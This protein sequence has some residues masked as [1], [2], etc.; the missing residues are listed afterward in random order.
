M[1]PRDLF[2][3]LLCSVLTLA[4][5]VPLAAAQEEPS[6]SAEDESSEDSGF[7]IRDN[8]FL[9]EE[10]YNQE[11]G[12][13]QHI[14]N[15]I[16]TWDR[17]RG[18]RSRTFDFVFTQEWPVGSQTHQ[19]SYTLPFQ[20]VSER[21]DGDFAAGGMCDMMLNY[22][23]QVFDGQNEPFAF[24]PRFSLILPTGDSEKGLG[25]DRVGYQV[26]LPMSYEKGHWACHLNAG[27]T[28]TPDV[29]VGL[30]PEFSATGRTLNGYNFGLS[31]I[32]EVTRDFHLMLESVVYLD[33]NL[34]EEATRDRTTQVILSPGF[35]WLVFEPGEAQ[36]VVGMGVPIGLSR[37]APD[38]GAL[39]YMSVE[40]RFRPKDED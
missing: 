32:R 29:V 37:D 39:F 38:I 18:V 21:G 3:P 26:N 7:K 10:A 28:V 17:N 24:A 12:V 40:H 33:E 23:L 11:P 4:A 16:P 1:S 15:W 8:S 22:R 2:A 34:L 35:R 14:F 5:G 19:F 30:A 13:V 36:C 25:N 27:M 20:H 31:V 6:Q 9:V